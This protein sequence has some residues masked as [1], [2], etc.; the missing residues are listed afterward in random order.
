MARKVITSVP[1]G[2]IKTPTANVKQTTTFSCGAATLHSVCAYWGV[3]LACEEDYFRVLNTDEETGTLPDRIISY[4]KKRGLHVDAKDCMTVAE[5]QR[6]LDKGR[7]VIVLVQAHGDKR[8]YRDYN[9]AGHYVIAIGYDDRKVYFEDP[10]MSGRRV[11]MTYPE[12]D[13][14]WHDRDASGKEYIRYGIAIWR[15]GKPSYIYQAEKMW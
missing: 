7:P 10:I 5:L 4:A 11:F 1:E 8:K 2:A 13:D 12:F 3:G 15:K 6:H 9:E 14:R